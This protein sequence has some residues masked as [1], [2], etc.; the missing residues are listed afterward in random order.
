LARRKGNAICTEGQYTFETVVL[1][2]EVV[3]PLKGE[4][5]KTKKREANGHS[6]LRINDP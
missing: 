4:K 3:T 6:I 1:T 2:S 5:K